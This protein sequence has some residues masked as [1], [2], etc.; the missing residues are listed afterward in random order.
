MTMVTF[1]VVV[2]AICILLYVLID[3]VAL[4]VAILCGLRPDEGSRRVMLSAVA[5]VR[6][7][8]E[9]W[10]ISAGLVLW[11]AFPVVFST[12]TSAF[13]VP[14]L[15]MGV[16]LILRGAAFRL[17]C[18]T[19]RILWLGDVSFC[20][21]SVLAAFMQGMMIGA[22]VEGLPMSGS[23]YIGGEFGWFS[24]FAVLCGL[25]LCFGYALLGACWLLREYE[26]TIREQVRWTIPHLAG[27]LLGFFIFF[28]FYVLVDMQVLL[29]WLERPYFLVFPAVGTVTTFLLAVTVRYE[30]YQRPFYMALAIFA[31][32]LGTLGISFWPYMIPFAVTIDVAG[33]PLSGLASRFWTAVLVVSL[34]TA[35]A[36][37]S[38][39]IF[40]AGSGRI[41]SKRRS[42]MPPVR[43][44]GE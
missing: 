37:R 20:G 30:P 19:K 4:G 24:L 34:I 43:G 25:G 9:A 3:G 31:A 6:R 41:L 8:N 27:G 14:A 33:V 15:L 18:Q 2:L 44:E 13:Y 1:W 21:G 12:L 10:L 17:R 5:S 16:G 29:R 7:G 39:V 40:D 22:L 23:R 28:F 26:G 36:L 11:G 32:A 38:Y 42:T 35:Y